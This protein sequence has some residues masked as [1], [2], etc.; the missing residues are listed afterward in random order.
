MKIPQKVIRSPKPKDRQYHGQQKRD[1]RTIND[2]E[3][4]TQKTTE[5]ATPTPL[6]TWSERMGSRMVRS[7]RS[8]D[9]TD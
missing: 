1:K 2:L 3:N 9:G 8:Y 4:N 6:E 5:W 7:S